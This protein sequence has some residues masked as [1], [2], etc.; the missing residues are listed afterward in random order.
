M[1]DA[2]A[3]A[4]YL[5]L[6]PLVVGTVRWASRVWDLP[7]EVRRKAVHV[8]MGLTALS[9][10]WVFDSVLSVAVLGLLSLL[11]LATIRRREARRC[12]AGE[13][14]GDSEPDA[15][16]VAVLHGVGRASLGDLWF[17]LAV[18]F[19]FAWSRQREGTE[20]LVLYL[21]P[22]LVLTLADAAGALVGTRYGASRFT[23]LSGWKSAEGCVAVFI[24]AFFSAH[25]PLLLLTGTGRA[26][27]LL[28]A[29]ILGMT[30][31]L[32]EAISTKGIDNLVV[33]LASVFLLDRFLPM[34]AS[35]LGWRL[36]VATLLLVFVLA[37]RK[38]ASLEGGALLAAALFGYGCW[39]F[40][41]WRFLVPPMILFL[42]HLL[43]THRLRRVW[44]P[45]HDLTPVLG[46][47]LSLI[48]WAALAAWRPDWREACLAAF[49]CGTVAHL[50]MINLTTRVFIARRKASTRM[51]RLA[52]AKGLALI[53][54][55]SWL[56]VTR[57]PVVYAVGFLALAAISRIALEGFVRLCGNPEPYGDDPARWWR[58][59]PVALFAGAL[60]F[61]L[62]LRYLPA[63]P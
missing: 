33:P 20:A 21:V 34:D 51:K 50:A 41:D 3:I 5:A 6:L 18:V 53:G 1:K 7:P 59:G 38:G 22:I 40:G 13:G 4:A 30:V 8:G 48:P 28:I 42:E 63:H 35:A 17:P 56:L 19:V 25:V 12:Q 45:R 47:G 27:S 29:L 57:D 14:A 43:V 44:Q 16:G 49:V 54:L 9:F 26:E 62:A 10:P 36:V 52:W 55:P 46:F 11:V 31:M 23:C 24:G 58:Q 60:V 39:A 37:C 15:G 61:A 2:F 32:F